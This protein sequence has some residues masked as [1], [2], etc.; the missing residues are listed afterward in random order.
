MSTP[1][2][3]EDHEWHQ[4]VITAARADRKQKAGPVEYTVPERFYREHAAR[5]MVAGELLRRGPANAVRVRLD[6]VAFDTLLVSAHICVRRPELPQS[7]RLSAQ[8]TIR[9]L[10]DERRPVPG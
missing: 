10:M 6:A 8:R 4:Q 7:L 5:G 1:P 2:L 3:H 9:R